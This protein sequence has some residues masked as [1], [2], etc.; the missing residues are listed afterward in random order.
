MEDGITGAGLVIGWGLGVHI[1][2]ID[3]LGE[4]I[5]NLI[6]VDGE[7]TVGIHVFNQE[8]DHGLDLVI[9]G[10]LAEEITALACIIVG[11]VHGYFIPV[12]V[13]LGQ[14][15]REV[16]AIITQ[17]GGRSLEFPPGLRGQQ[18]NG[19]T[20]TMGSHDPFQTLKLLCEILEYGG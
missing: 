7:S 5:I 18:L 20:N 13:N 4:Q 11:A 6:G 15:G 12:G 3:I 10:T 9:V 16:G 19:T 8:F 14:V 17:T 2:R 1:V